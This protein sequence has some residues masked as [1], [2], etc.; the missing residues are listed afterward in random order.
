[1]LANSVPPAC[2]RP[3]DMSQRSDRPPCGNDG[4][5]PRTVSNQP[6]FSEFLQYLHANLGRVQSTV[7]T[8]LEAMKNARETR[9]L[10]E[11]ISALQGRY[12]HEVMV[13]QV[14]V[15][16]EALL[17]GAKAGLGWEET[18]A[19]LGVR[20]LFLR[21]GH[22]L[23][24][25]LVHEVGL[26][27]FRQT[28]D[29]CLVKARLGLRLE[30]VRVLEALIVCELGEAELAR[31]RSPEDIA[32]AWSLETFHGRRLLGVT[33]LEEKAYDS[34]ISAWKLRQAGKA[35]RD[36]GIAAWRGRVKGH[37]PRVPLAL[38]LRRT[39]ASPLPAATLQRISL[40][41]K[42][43]LQG[44]RQ[45]KTWRESL[46]HLDVATSMTPGLVQAVERW[47]VDSVAM[48][49]FCG[50]RSFQSTVDQL[51]LTPWGQTYLSD[52]IVAMI[53]ATHLA[54]GTT[55]QQVT[56]KW[57]LGTQAQEALEFE[58]RRARRLKATVTA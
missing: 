27:Y 15:V 58:T 5:V 28:H 2:G 22:V 31:G 10:R 13:K 21:G 48:K 51:G 18:L 19:V 40:L 30:G 11:Q 29:A 43:I 41:Q 45:G 44:V 12:P 4:P 50:T 36:D 1:M 14:A 23:E 57:S 49:L 52:G 8:H 56:A 26:D 20:D 3:F 16:S 55:L 39:H 6:T 46:S 47:L 54:R 24:R 35:I 9:P 38:R 42:P 17:Q 7:A 53:G 37:G 25:W 33:A 32:A 34:C